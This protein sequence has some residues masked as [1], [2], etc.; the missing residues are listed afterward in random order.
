MDVNFNP[1]CPGISYHVILLFKIEN[2][3]HWKKTTLQGTNTL[4]QRKWVINTMHRDI[5][6]AQEEDGDQ[7]RSET[8]P[9]ATELRIH[10]LPREQRLEKLIPDL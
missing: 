8:F 9:L 3:S 1:G 5:N 7:T 4:A 6:S 2:S 10:Q